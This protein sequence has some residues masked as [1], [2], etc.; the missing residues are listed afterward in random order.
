MTMEGIAAAVGMSKVTVYGYFK[1]KDAV[2]AGVADRLASRLLDVVQTELR[3]S[4]SIHDKV[5]NALLAK[6]RVI[7]D[8]VRTSP[9]AS[10]LFMAKNLTS[11]DRFRETDRQIEAE[12]TAALVLEKIDAKEAATLASVLFAASQGIANHASDFEQLENGIGRLM[13]ILPIP[14]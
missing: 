12:L 3:N 7:F 2:F 13:L 14:R 5:R 4:T 6:H 8:L 11:Q 1:D 9:F 10:E